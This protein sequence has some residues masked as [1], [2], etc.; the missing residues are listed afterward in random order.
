[1][2]AR[3]A[4][5]VH[6]GAGPAAPDDDAELA[7]AGCLAAARAGSAV[8]AAGGSALDA[9]VAAVVALED[10]PAFNAGTGSCLN[11]EGEVE[12]D[13][14]VMQ[15][16]SLG[17]G[18]VALVRTVKNPVLLARAVM[19]RTKHVFLAGE[20][21]HRLALDAGMAAVDP[22]TLVVPRM[23][24]RYQKQKV[25]ASVPA[26][27]GTVGAVAV[28]A[29]G[30]VAAA[31]STGGT[32]FKRLGRIGDTPLLGCG[33]YADD[34]AGAASAT[35]HG[36][37]IIKVTLTRSLCDRLRGGA[38]P[39]AAAEACLQDLARVRGTG[40]VIAVD[41]QGRVGWAF[42]TDRM[43]RAS[44]DASGAERVEFR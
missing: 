32:G 17:G 11:E 34:L 30:H 21:A 22:R 15:G 31:T 10:N 19:E 37:S 9:A 43:A 42:N 4:I 44:V 2:S 25:G 27:P 7:K 24:A 26:A 29:N 18:A 8:L 6:G 35:G 23:L 14:S 40:G 12:M 20:G 5:V 28:D 39:Q 41:P 1:M 16:D 36:E 38:T 3:S 13:A 33:T